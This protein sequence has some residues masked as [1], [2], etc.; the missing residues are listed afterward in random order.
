MLWTQTKLEFL[1]A[2]D[3]H[4]SASQVPGPTGTH[5]HAHYVIYDNSHFISSQDRR[6]PSKMSGNERTCRVA[7][8]DAFVLNCRIGEDVPWGR[9]VKTVN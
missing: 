3:S 7:L 1:A 4:T 8:K 5:H 2:S 9:G 6:T